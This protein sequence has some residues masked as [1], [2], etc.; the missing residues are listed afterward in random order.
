MIGILG[1]VLLYS[2]LGLESENISDNIPY[3]PNVSLPVGKLLMQYESITD[4]PVPPPIGLFPVTFT[5][6]DTVFFR[7]DE[8][9]F[10]RDNI[11]YLKLRFDTTNRFP[12]QIEVELYYIN[13][14]GEKSYLTNEPIIVP[15][16]VI[17]TE[18]IITREQTDLTDVML[19]DEQI[20]DMTWVSQYLIQVTVRDLVM[21]P[22]VR[23]EIANYS[24][25]SALGAEAHL[26]VQ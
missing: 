22:V 26:D 9:I 6:R 13:S 19:S 5:D 3:Q 7:L 17:D 10:V 1:L 20:D 14:N 4:L 16:A 8:N 11:K 15:A 24:V 23:N 12:A 21:T 25:R 2:C 18:G